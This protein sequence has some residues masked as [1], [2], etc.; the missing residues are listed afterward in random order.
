MEQ[1]FQDIVRYHINRFIFD[2]G[3][4]PDV[5]ELAGITGRPTAEV[6]QALDDLAAN[7]A[8]VLHPNSHRIWVAHPFSL[9]PTLFWVESEQQSWYS[10]CTWCSLGVAALVEEGDVTIYTKLNG[11]IKPQEIHIKDGQ[12]VEDHL[13]VHFVVPMTRIWENV[14]YTCSNMLTFESEEAID[15][16]CRQQNVEKGDVQ[17]INRIWDLARE[18]Y[19]YYLSPQWTRKTKEEASRI[20]NS[21]GLTNDFWKV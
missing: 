21:V 17:P 1:E 15:L 16:W 4:A 10:N 18:W 13:L 12:V 20:F 11:T 8:L 3:H 5:D 14:I 19:G 6:R 7:H 9:M 2:R